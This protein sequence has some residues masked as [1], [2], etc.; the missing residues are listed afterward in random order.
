MNLCLCVHV[1]KQFFFLREKNNF[2]DHSLRRK[3]FLSLFAI[4]YIVRE[5]CGCDFDS[6]ARKGEDFP[7]VF[8][9]YGWTCLRRG[10]FPF[11]V[12]DAILFREKLILI[13]VHLASLTAIRA[14]RS[15]LDS[16]ITVEIVYT[17]KSDRRRL[18][19]FN[20]LISTAMRSAWYKINL[21]SISLSEKCTKREK[22][23]ANENSNYRDS[24]FH[25]FRKRI[26]FIDK[27]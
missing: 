26:E 25:S 27:K 19:A 6:L 7:K 12:Y 10:I 17:S 8:L 18:I 14:F 2:L 11:E 16:I 15:L 20:N 9:N 22:R 5:T 3:V 23:N 4:A 13:R 21:K 1:G 24:D